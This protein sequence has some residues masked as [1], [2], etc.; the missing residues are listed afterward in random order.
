MRSQRTLGY[1]KLTVA[2]GETTRGQSLRFHAGAIL[3]LFTFA[4]LTLLLPFAFKLRARGLFQVL[5]IG[6]RS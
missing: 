4:L 3:L 6:L 5:H 1:S 2:N